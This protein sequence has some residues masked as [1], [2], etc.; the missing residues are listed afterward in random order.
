MTTLRESELLLRMALDLTSSL[1]TASRPQRLVDS[2]HAALPEADAV[3]LLRADGEELVPIAVRGLQQQLL[4]QRFRRAEQPRLDAIC[5]SAEPMQFAA[6]STL[7]DPYDGYV[8]GG[9]TLSERVH[10][11]LG[12][13][14]RVEGDL[15]GVLTMDALDAG[16]FDALDPSF[17]AAVGALTAA[18]MRTNDLLDTLERQAS[19]RG[20][21]V[22]DL[23]RD[24]LVQHGGLLIGPSK[25]MAQLRAE[26]D[27]VAGSDF[28]VLVTGE[29]GTGK[30]LVVRTLHS[31]SSR[32]EQPLIQ[33]NCAALPESI[34]ESELFGHSKGAFT[35]AVDARPGRFQAADG[36]TLFLDEIGELPLH[37]QPKLLRVLQAGEVQS[38]G[39]DG[40]RR[41]DVRVLA[42]TNRDLDAEVRA[43]RFRADLLYRL[44]VCRLRLPPL[45]Q[46]PDDILPLAG[47]A[48]DRIRRQLGTGPVRI[49]PSGQ[50]ALLQYD[51]P[52][53]V[54]ELENVLARA[55]LRAAARGPAGAEV[56]VG[57]ADLGLVASPP[58]AEVSDLTA[59]S[60][61]A[62]PLV[63]PG[64][65]RAAVQEFER[66]LVRAALARSGDNW[67]RA[68][69]LLGM[70]RSNLHHLG[71]R[72]GLR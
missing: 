55:V 37:L 17:V 30:E 57:A 31:R 64:G 32:A 47:H 22:R 25:A 44:D 52:G 38:V 24:A 59:P 9:H 63:G 70:H 10:S 69:E 40:V 51:W 34:A 43:G 67:S 16:S 11:C 28:P 39:S 61:P 60:A 12:C 27:L 29:T 13:P 33:V 49:D 66:G 48:G 19:L 6:D 14:L 58:R 72:L 35:G 15:V 41:V 68:A 50:A 46:R 21:I 45:R 26:I 20:Q 36:G 4:G 42:A 7:P 56:A 5:V 53:N 8:L 62:P 71:R 54:R 18:A 2:V 1:S 65:L 3:A 23:V